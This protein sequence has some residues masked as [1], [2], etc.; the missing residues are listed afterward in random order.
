M[1][2]ITTSEA[3]G[4]PAGRDGAQASLDAPRRAANI[5]FATLIGVSGAFTLIALAMI[6]GGSSGSFVDLPAL[7]IVG[8]GSFL[9]TTISFSFDEVMSAQRIMLR[10][11]VYHAEHPDRAAEQMLYL[12]DRA[13]RVGALA[14]ESELPSLGRSP[15]LYRAISLVVDGTPPDEVEQVMSGEVQATALRH[16][17]STGVLRRAGEV[18]PAMGLIG[19]LVGLI[20]MLGNL[21]DPSSIGPA[22][23]VALLTTFYG[24]ILAHI[25]FFPLAN[26]LERNSDVETMVNHIY[27]LGAASISRQENPRRLETL[28]NTILPPARRVHFFD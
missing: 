3:S 9:V 1:A 15:F 24:A 6:I 27:A 7:L 14:L 21:D 17:R 19:T 10:T 18:A 2:N 11:L 12:A 13:R 25:V 23:A 16:Q 20:Q 4:G 5:D 28:L 8:A 22:M 26:K